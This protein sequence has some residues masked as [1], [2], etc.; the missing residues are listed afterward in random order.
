M[1][2]GP[3]WECFNS[4]SWVTLIIYKAKILFSP[5]QCV[6]ETFDRI[7]WEYGSNYKMFHFLML[8]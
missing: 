8:F 7:F 6:L 2:P 1:F 4:L 5:Y 3:F